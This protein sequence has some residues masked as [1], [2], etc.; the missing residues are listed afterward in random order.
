[1]IIATRLGLCKLVSYILDFQLLISNIS[2]VVNIMLCI[3]YVHINSILYLLTSV[4]K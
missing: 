1:M 3:I 2:Y 4:L